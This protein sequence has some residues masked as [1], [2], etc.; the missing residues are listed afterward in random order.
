MNRQGA[1]LLWACLDEPAGHAARLVYADWL[2][3]HGLGLHATFVRGWSGSAR[4]AAHWQRTIFGH[5]EGRP[6]MPPA[7]AFGNP[8]FMSSTLAEVVCRPVAWIAGWHIAWIAQRA[9]E[10][11]P[12]F[13]LCR[14]RQPWKWR[15]WAGLEDG[16]YPQGYQGACPE[17]ARARRR[18]LG[19]LLVCRRHY[20]VCGRGALTSGPPVPPP[21]SHAR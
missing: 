2:Q 15:V 9:E 7:H 8:L 14:D 5:H 20:C 13:A 16:P 3:E 1:R 21:A 4:T 11:D 18:A 17:P 12:A 19:A 6:A 10:V